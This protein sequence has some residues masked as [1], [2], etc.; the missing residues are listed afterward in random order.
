ML[1]SVKEFVGY[2]IKALDGK[3]GTAK[4]LCFDD[5]SWA[6]RYLVVDTGRWLPGRLVLLAPAALDHPDWGRKTLPV[7]LTREQV[8]K[9]PPID[10]D[11]PVSMQR[12]AEL[13]RYYGWP[14]YP[15]YPPPG[16]VLPTPPPPP[17]KGQQPESSDPH[18]RSFMEVAGYHIQA[19]DDRIGHLDDM[20]V[21]DSTWH[22]RYLVVDTRNWLPGR[23]VLVAPQ[24][25]TRI[26]WD[27]R[28]LSV[29]LPL[30]TVRNSP[31]LDYGQPVNREYELRLYDYYGRPKYW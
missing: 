25:V 15:I 17:P 11:K 30:E 29:D 31:E 14:L 28:I 21:E 8:E 1:R 27:D 5:V 7:L 26:S 2:D 22:L 13:H 10:A 3:I 19:T 9:S 4:D 20:I 12:E 23:K 24:W 6:V 18:L 16:D